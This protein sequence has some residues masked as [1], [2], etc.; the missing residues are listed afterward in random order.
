MIKVI[1]QDFIKPECVE[2][3]LAIV[4]EL[5]AAT[6]ANDAGCIKYELCRNVNEPQRFF[7]LEEWENQES[8]D[9]HMNSAHF[10]TLIPKMA[11]MTTNPPVI[12]ILEK[13][14]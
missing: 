6:N 1:A 9:A 13:V 3:Y 10:T 2:G 11:G 4:E 8:L 14:Y 12:T 5:V 7:M